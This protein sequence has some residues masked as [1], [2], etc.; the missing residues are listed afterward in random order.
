M[1]DFWN[2]V[3]GNEGNEGDKNDANKGAAG[4][5]VVKELGKNTE[6]LS[7]MNAVRPSEPNGN[8]YNLLVSTTEKVR[9]ILSQSNQLTATEGNEPPADA[10][11]SRP[12]I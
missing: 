10:N 5:F 2:R 8:A 7:K 11:S 1:P 6:S 9:T 4:Q 12:T 3:R